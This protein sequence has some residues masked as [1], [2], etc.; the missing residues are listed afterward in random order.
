[1][2]GYK[3]N[4]HLLI[5]DV[6]V[7]FSWFHKVKQPCSSSIVF[8][9]SILLPIFRD[10]L[11]SF[12]KIILIQFYF[13]SHKTFGLFDFFEFIF[14]GKNKWVSKA[15]FLWCTAFVGKVFMT[16]TFNDFWL[17]IFCFLWCLMFPCYENTF[18]VMLLSLNLNEWFGIL[19]ITRQ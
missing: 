1:M 3:K 14:R 16:K 7:T 10:F 2:M 15:G 9:L 4:K 18:S 17:P 8:Y 11:K 13:Y 19:L 12:N 6:L 5:F